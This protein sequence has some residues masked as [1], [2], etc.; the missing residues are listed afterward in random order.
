MSKKKQTNFLWSN[1]KKLNLL[2]IATHVAYR[3]Q[4]GS[5]VEQHPCFCW[6]PFKKIEKYEKNC[7][8]LYGFIGHM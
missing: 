5:N 3:G 8:I 6:L 2:H 7:N 4:K 1:D